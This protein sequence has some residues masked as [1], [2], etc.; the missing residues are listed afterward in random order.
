MSYQ[1]ALCR[2]QLQLCRHSQQTRP[3]AG[4]GIS[5]CACATAEEPC[6]SHVTC[7]F[8]RTSACVDTPATHV[9]G[10]V[11]AQ[12][13]YQWRAVLPTGVHSGFSQVQ[14]AQCGSASL[15]RQP[16]V[17][18]ECAVPSQQV[19]ARCPAAAA[20]CSIVQAQ[21]VTNPPVPRLAVMCSAAVDT[22]FAPQHPGR[23]C[24]FKTCGRST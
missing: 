23:C 13:G 12:A 7:H 3:P 21:Q 6:M 14:Q 10:Y 20:C 24:C 11:C 9:V 15:A 4:A 2:L 17:H 1:R 18:A 8:C 19:A 16:A 5:V 22:L